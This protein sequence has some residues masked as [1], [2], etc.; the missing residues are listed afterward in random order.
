MQRWLRD[1]WDRVGPPRFR[2]QRCRD[3]IADTAFSR[4]RQWSGTAEAGYDVNWLGQR[5][6][7]R[8]V[9]GWADA[10]RLQERR[11]DPCPYPALNEEVFEWLTLLDAVSHA[12]GRFVMVEAGAGYGRWLVSAALALRQAHPGM[13]C[14]LIGIEGETHHYASLLQHFRDNGLDPAEHRLIHGAVSDRD[15]EGEFALNDNPTGWWGQWL[16]R[17]ETALI[18]EANLRTRSIVT[19]SIETLLR[20]VGRVD[21]MDFD[22][23]GAEEVAIGGGIDV[24]TEKV[25]R[26]F[27]ETHGA[28]IHK[29]VTESFRSR[30]WRCTH[31]YGWADG[32]LSQEMTPFGPIVFDGYGVQCWINPS[33][34]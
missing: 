2:R 20:D 19:Y 9:H 4:F 31:S 3:Y 21:H 22:I 28:G 5:T 18:G 14:T 17:P 32:S 30:G 7:V 10:A 26:V 29:S 6:D 25:R 23:Q 33:V 8:F 27:V 16:M 12:R 34:R 24:M 13:P 1:A 11:Y 15:G